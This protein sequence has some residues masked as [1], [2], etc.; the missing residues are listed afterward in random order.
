MYNTFLYKAKFAASF[1]RQVAAKFLDI[2]CHFY[3][4]KNHKIAISSTTT[5]AGEKICTDLKSLGLDKFL[6]KT[7]LCFEIYNFL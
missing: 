6:V 4:V 1:C 5:E 2:F 3:L 7:M